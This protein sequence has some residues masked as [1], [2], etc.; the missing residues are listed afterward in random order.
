MATVATHTKSFLVNVPTRDT[1]RFQAW[2][3]EMGWATSLVQDGSISDPVQEPYTV[4]ELR[5]GIVESE[6]QYAAGEYYT[7][8]EVHEL[9]EQFVQQQLQTV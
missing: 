7:Q 6:Q 9:M 2:M 8:E 3:D 4:E 1:K 5:E